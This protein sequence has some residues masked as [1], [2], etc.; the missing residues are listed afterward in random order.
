MTLSELPLSAVRERLALGGLVLDFG[1]ASARLRSDVPALAEVVQR[2]YHAFNVDDAAAFSVATMDLRRA[3]GWR[4][5]LRPQVE[6][7]TDGGLLFEPFPADT[8][9]PLVEWGLNY[10]FAD[11]LNAF[12]LLHAGVVERD[13]RAIVLPAMPGSGKSTL[14]AA[15]SLRG[16]RLLSDEFG[17]VRLDDAQLLPLLRPVALKNASIDVIRAF[18]PEAVLG[19]RFEKTRKGTVAHLAPTRDAVRRCKEAARPALVV[20]PQY[21]AGTALEIEPM[22]KSRAFAKLAV[23]SF[24]YEILGRAGFD[25][26]AALLDAS[27][28]YRLLYN[29]LDRAIAALTELLAAG[30]G[31]EADAR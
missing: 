4:R 6:F 26:V 19:P 18:A 2:V 12:L 30:K 7:I 24:N 31:A 29:D 11:R 10:L 1:A 23:N 25:A 8:H 28:C 15:L 16:F 17:V 22:M 21:D 27:A 9:L 3:R 5:W 13:G 20:F 14:T